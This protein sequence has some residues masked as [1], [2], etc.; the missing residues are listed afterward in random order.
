[1]SFEL[2]F[3][4]HISFLK[5]K[6]FGLHLND[7]FILTGSTFLRWSLVSFSFSFIGL[8][9]VLGSIRRSTRMNIF[10]FEVFFKSNTLL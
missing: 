6:I 5:S 10:Y 8:P 7:Y 4:I 2:V 3:G 1:M 9:I